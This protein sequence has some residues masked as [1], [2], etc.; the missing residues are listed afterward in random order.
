M[1]VQSNR[2][3]RTI[4]TY[5]KLDFRGDWEYFFGDYSFRPVGKTAELLVVTEAPTGTLVTHFFRV[6]RRP[7]PG[8]S[9]VLE[10]D[11]VIAPNQTNIVYIP[12]RCIKRV[13]GDATTC[14][15]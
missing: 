2:G 6:R 1:P 5:V 9:S 11:H 7:A 10:T 14:T 13:K 8:P 3:E 12:E 4:L 15:R